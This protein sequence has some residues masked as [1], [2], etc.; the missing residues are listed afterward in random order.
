[1][2]ESSS[3]GLSSVPDVEI[4]A[5]GLFK[6]VL[7]KVI[8]PSNE[9]TYKCIVRGFDWANY[10]A[11]I[12]DKIEEEIGEMRM[13]TE[14]LGGGRIQH[15]R[16]EKKILVYG[17]SVGFGRADHSIAV[18]KLIKAYPDYESMTFVIRNMLRSLNV[19]IKSYFVVIL[20]P[21]D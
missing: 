12:Y 17:Y 5:N 6:Y 2:A 8:D 10:H 9:D 20:L 21:K 13:K 4:D 16:L 15:D 11:D 18:E 19:F 1:M 7:I 14:C 3:L